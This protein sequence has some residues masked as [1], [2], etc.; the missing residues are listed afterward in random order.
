MEEI[1]DKEFYVSATNVYKKWLSSYGAFAAEF[2]Q[3][4]ICMR[5]L[6]P[7]LFLTDSG[8]F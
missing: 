4:K 8:A 3:S 1:Q 5:S 2:M 6:F 7:G